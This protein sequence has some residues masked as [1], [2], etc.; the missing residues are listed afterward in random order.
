MH[1]LKRLEL[2]AAALLVVTCMVAGRAHADGEGPADPEARMGFP[3]G[4][5]SPSTVTTQGT[6]SIPPDDDDAP[7]PTAT[8]S[9]R[10]GHPPGVTTDVRSSTWQLFIAWLQAQALS[11]IN[12]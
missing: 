11:I 10:M 6:V 12:R 4:V 7:E 9:A 3:P 2:L 1:K 8:T 5:S